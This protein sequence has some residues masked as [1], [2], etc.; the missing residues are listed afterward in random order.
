M[1]I[2]A[3][4]YRTKN[5]RNP[6]FNLLYSRI[7]EQA[8][9]IKTEEGNFLRLL[10]NF[11]KEKK[12]IHLH[13]AT[14]L[15]GSKFLII[16]FF[17]LIIN[18]C[19]FFI[20][21]IKGIKIVWTMHNYESHDFKYPLIDK[22]GRKLIIRLADSIIVHTKIGKEYLKDNYKRENNVFVIPHGNYVDVYG[23]LVKNRFEIRSKLGY[24][25]NDLVFL[26]LGM[27]RPYK[28]LEELIEFFNQFTNENKIKFLIL[29]KGDNLYIEKLKERIKNKNIIIDNR[30]IPNSEAPSFFALADFS[31]FA[32]RKIL[33]SGAA[34]L[35]LSYALPVIAPKKGD[36][37]D[38][39]EDKENGFLFDNEIELK[40]IILK[41]KNF[42]PEQ[43]DQMRENAL[44][45][46]K[47]LDW[48][49]I[50]KQT[51]EIYLSA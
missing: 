7:I 13:W 18:F 20:Y 23:K 43:K 14:K 30:F 28:G 10:F 2:Y 31:V 46:A 47:K 25:E 49:E 29:G 1:H 24:K 51:I 39:I 9:N 44:E 11:Q 15:Y 3:F 26:N 32:Y 35:S 19:L 48:V 50:A 36:L 45:T 27:I 12:I 40:E 4:P 22:V 37:K 34:I 17:K 33:T 16:S 5:N 38:L 6:Y 42:S 8:P 21:K 41:I